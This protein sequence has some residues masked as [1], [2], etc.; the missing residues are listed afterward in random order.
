MTKKDYSALFAH[1]KHIE[2]KTD[3]LERVLMRIT[4]LERRAAQ[5]RL[6][7][8]SLSATLSLVGVIFSLRFVWSALLESGFIEYLSLA[9][10]DWSTVALYGKEFALTLIESLPLLGITLLLSATFVLLGSLAYAREYTKRSFLHVRL[11]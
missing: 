11:A 6:A 1:Q 4:L 2:P 10:S 8:F 9:A 5:I 7:F 3:L